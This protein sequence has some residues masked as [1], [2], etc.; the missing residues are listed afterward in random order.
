MTLTTRMAAMNTRDFMVSLLNSSGPDASRNEF[1]CHRKRPSKTESARGDFESGWC[2][3]PF[4][5]VV[6]YHDR[7]CPDEFK[8][9]A[10]L[11]RNLFRCANFFYVT[12]ENPVEDII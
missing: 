1:L 11:I 10:I 4:V 9:K 8:W 2:L 6:I 5:F 12:F 3:F 7:N